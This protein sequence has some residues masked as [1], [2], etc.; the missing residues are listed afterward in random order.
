M[1]SPCGAN[2]A[3]MS[4]SIRNYYVISMKDFSL[5]PRRHRRLAAHLFRLVWSASAHGVVGGEILWW[6]WN[7]V[8]GW[9]VVG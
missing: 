3:K 5:R 9:A 4:I 6:F 2:D 7:Y 8:Y 1:L